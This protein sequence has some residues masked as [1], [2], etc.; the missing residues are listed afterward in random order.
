MCS[1]YGLLNCSSLENKSTILESLNLLDSLIFEE[2]E[3]KLNSLSSSNES[4]MNFKLD[5]DSLKTRL[6]ETFG[7][8]L[9]KKILPNQLNI[10]LIFYFKVKHKQIETALNLAEKYVDFNTLVTVCEIKND[11][12]LLETYLDKFSH[13]V[14]F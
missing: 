10:L 6:I 4:Y 12:E 9:K 2:Y 7:M 13:K 1:E 14:K 8:D 3:F 11:F 5:Y